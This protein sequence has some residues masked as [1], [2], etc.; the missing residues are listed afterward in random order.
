MYG[1]WSF[2]E[3]ATRIGWRRRG[4]EWHVANPF[5]GGGKDRFL[6]KLGTMS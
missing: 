1:D 2:P 3:T 5:H 4:E 6:N